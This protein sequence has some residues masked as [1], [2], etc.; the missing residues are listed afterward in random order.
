MSK[1]QAKVQAEVMQAYRDIF[2]HTPQGR[3]ILKDQLKASML[4]VMTGN[5]DNNDLQ[6]LEG[7]RDMVRRI[8]N[9]LALDEDQ[10]LKLATGE[11]DDAE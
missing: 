6:H 8:I 9:I 4:F 5:R 11:P 7:S 2:L 10:L 3:M 1:E